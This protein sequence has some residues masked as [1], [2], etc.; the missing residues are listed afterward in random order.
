MGVLGKRADLKYQADSCK[1]EEVIEI[2][3]EILRSSGK[4]L[5]VGGSLVYST[6]TLNTEE[7]Q[8]LIKDFLLENTDFEK[9]EISA[10]YKKFLD[11]EGNVQ[12]LPFRDNKN[13]FFVAKLRKRGL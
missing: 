12:T 4:I 2:Q 5:K 1:F 10:K 6:C 11:E 3:K 8:K 9:M 7:N 13:G